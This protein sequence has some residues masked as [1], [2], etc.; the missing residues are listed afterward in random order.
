MSDKTP[1]T[2]RELRKT[3]LDHRHDTESNRC[4]AP[5]IVEQLLASELPRMAVESE[6]GGLETDPPVSLEVYE[7]LA[8]TEASVA[9]I[10]WNSWLPCLFGRYLSKTAR[11]EIFAV[12]GKM[13]SSST[14]ATGKAVV[15]NGGYRVSGRWA[16]VSGCELAAWIPVMCMVE[17]NGGPRM[18]QSG[19]P[20]LRLA[21][22]PRG[23]YEILDTWHVGG[24]RGTGSHDIVVNGAFVEE[25]KV[26]SPFSP[27]QIDKPIGKLP[28][29]LSMGAGCGSI[30][31]GIAQLALNTVVDLGRSKVAVDPT[32]NMRDRAWVQ[33]AVALHGAAIQS[34][35][36]HLRTTFA[37]IWE[38][39]QAGEEV[40]DELLADGFSA[41]GAATKVAKEAVSALY[42]AAGTSAIY[43]DCPLERAERD[44]RTILQHVIMQPVWLENAGRVKLGL[45]PEIPLFRV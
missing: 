36:L 35:R 1:A 34:A 16:L 33:A 42:D 39:C 23:S 9:W 11:S 32:P 25:E 5:P 10:V 3:I 4:L 40:T 31:L 14:R 7:E 27:S 2:A 37:R 22:L 26:F 12:A 41:V 24:L 38:K 21:F 19:A 44:L 28:I 18:L 29:I 13:Y 20:D 43:V 15:E 8:S 30:I 17:E 6:L 45:N